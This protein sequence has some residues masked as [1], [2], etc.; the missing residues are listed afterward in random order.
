MF[1][2]IPRDKARA[3]CHGCCFLTLD[4]GCAIRHTREPVSVMAAITRCNTLLLK[5]GIPPKDVDD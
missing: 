3:L 5:R 2:P 1:K 4:R